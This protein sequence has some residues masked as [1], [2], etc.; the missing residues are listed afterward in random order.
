[1][2]SIDSFINTPLLI[3]AGAGLILFILLLIAKIR[4]PN[5]ISIIY[6]PVIG[7]FVG[8][9]LYSAINHVFFQLIIITMIIVV[10]FI[11]Y[12][13][14]LA[15]AD[16]EK[17][18]AKKA[19]KESEQNIDYAQIDKQALENQSKK[20]EA[21]IQAN[22]ELVTKASQ[23][24]KE[25]DSLSSFLEHFNKLITEKTNSDGCA[26]LVYDEFDNI[27]AVKSVNGVFP[28]PY[29]LPEDL[30]HKTI[31]VET[32]FRYSNFSLTGNV[33]GQI[34]S[35]AQPVNIKDS[36]K[37]HRIYQN[38]PEDFL[39]CGPFM[40]I[41]VKQNGEASS[42]ICL[43]RKPGAEPFSDEEFET[44]C[45]MASGLGVALQPLNSF[46][47]Y[48]EHAE[49]TKEGEIATKF[50]K[51]MLPEKIPAINKLSIGKY[52]LPVE[53]V[54]G[55]Y[56]DIIPSRKDRITFIMADV[57]G[58]GM[59]SLVVMIMIRAMLRLL[60]NT[61]QTSA[62]ILEWVNKAICSEK[63]S[64]DHF[65]S[66]SLINYDSVTNKAQVATS[67]SNPVLLYSAADKTISKI[68]VSCEPIG[69]EKNTDF[70]NIELNL[71]AG[72]ILVTCTDGLL[73][74][75]NE[76]G[77]QYSLD[78]LSKIIKTNCNLN[79]KDIAA[80]VKDNIRKFCGNTQQY[81]DQSLLVV[82][83]QE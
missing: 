65:A 79:G 76:S 74:C 40:F 61:N 24:F 78:S 23:F 6:F 7:L 35:E 71:N 19:K 31:R 73:E 63:N 34:F 27:L 64:M 60:A 77:V 30:P 39:K 29:K 75:L 28:P 51:T 44:A 2:N 70:K 5:S 37:D 67:G 80:K 55:D 16:P 72:D 25:D 53:N 57:A 22:S 62:T 17:I 14:V 33:F 45:N 46:L 69:V 41:P 4:R 26:I 48:A 52:E 49:L 10:I 56:Y 83:I 59:N 15:V 68:S 47:A 3:S 11:A 8:G 81:D 1:M 13:F 66:V 18:A 38:G 50:Q 12:A 20:Y 36:V 43:S 9:L 42:L 58:K 21:M 82:K 54:C 32:N